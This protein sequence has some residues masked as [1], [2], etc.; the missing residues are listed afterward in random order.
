MAFV[1]ELDGTVRRR[2]AAH[3][4]RHG[5]AARGRTNAG[6]DRTTV[7]YGRIAEFACAFAVARAAEFDAFV[8]GGLAAMEAE[9]ARVAGRD[10]EARRGDGGAGA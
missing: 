5:F 2:L 8:A 7:D 3:A 1:T 9:S 6:K 10:R 4:R